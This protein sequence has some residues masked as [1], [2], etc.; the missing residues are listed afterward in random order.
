MDSGWYL[1]TDGKWYYFSEDHDGWY[2]H[3][4]TGWYFDKKDQKWYYME[5]ISGVM[6]TGWLHEDGKWYYLTPS[7]TAQ[8]YFMN[9]AG[10]WEYQE[11]SGRPLGSMYSNEITPDGYPVDASGEW[12]QET[13]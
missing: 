6:Q 11:N 13:P 5:P 4:I 1:D 8:T 12:L 7:N 10:K 9:D 3:M 2:G